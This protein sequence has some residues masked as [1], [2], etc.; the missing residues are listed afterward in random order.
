[1]AMEN[2]GKFLIESNI[3]TESQLVEA[4]VSCA[5][6][7]LNVASIV[8]RFEVLDKS[9]QL[10]IMIKMAKTGRSYIECGHSLG[11]LT[12]IHIAKIEDLRLKNSKN[13]FHI[14]VEQKVCDLGV[15][16]KNIDEFI[17][18]L[19]D[20]DELFNGVKEYRSKRV[21]KLV[22]EPMPAPIFEKKSPQI[23]NE[24]M[25]EAKVVVEQPVERD[26]P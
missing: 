13:L 10:N 1:M 2:F 7:T 9:Q 17:A 8:N 6:Q 22:K 23:I 3:I 25:V 16:I 21:M 4:A 20:S 18:E 11:I 14:L 24:A 15:L 5:S 19:A 26:V 12:E